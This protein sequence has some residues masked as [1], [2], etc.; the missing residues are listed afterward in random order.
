MNS[1]FWL[2]IAVM[3]NYQRISMCPDDHLGM[4]SVNIMLPNKLLE[5]CLSLAHFQPLY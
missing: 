1:S 5:I 3:P 4:V 2:N